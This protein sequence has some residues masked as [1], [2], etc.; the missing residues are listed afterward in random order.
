MASFLKRLA[1][2][3]LSAPPAAIVTVV[4]FIY[5][6]LKV[7]PACM[8]MIHRASADEDEDDRTAFEG[9]LRFLRSE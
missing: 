6:L 8:P 4:P 1:R 7:H 2:L 3:A 9:T 5:N